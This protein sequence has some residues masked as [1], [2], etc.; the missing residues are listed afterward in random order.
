MTFD[1]STILAGLTQAA[2]THQAPGS[3]YAD[4]PT[5]QRTLPDGTVIVHLRRRMLPRPEDQPLVG[6]LRVTE[7]DRIDRL[8]ADVTGD[9]TRF[10]RLADANLV[11]H[12]D[13]MVAEPGS[14][15]RVTGGEPGA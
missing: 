6:H 1:P 7:G 15:I 14:T 9:P 11:T 8:A 2:P 12:P 13:E 10:W 5:A 3:R 4:T